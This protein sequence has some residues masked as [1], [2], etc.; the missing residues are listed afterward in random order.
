MK[1]KFESSFARDLRR[2]RDRKLRRRIAEAIR[3]FEEAHSLLEVAGI[4]KLRDAHDAYRLRIG[5]YRLGLLVRDDVVILV[6]CLDRKDIY[7]YF[8]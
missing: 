2:V 3:R 7:R 6:R 4:K 5:E 8:P 1:V